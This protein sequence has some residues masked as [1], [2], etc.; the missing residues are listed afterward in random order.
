MAQSGLGQCDSLLR[1]QD[2]AG[3]YIHA[4]RAS[5]A[6]RLVERSQWESNTRTLRCP[7]ASP[8]AVGFAT[9]PLHA[10]LVERVLGSQPAANLLAAG[11]FEDLGAM[12]Q[13]G[14][15]HF[16]PEPGIAA[17]PRR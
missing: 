6:L 12:A 1:A 13:A 7:V 15:H 17:P 2:T 5:R 14:W 9:L 8:G 10:A 16:Q 3:A 4:R 11:D